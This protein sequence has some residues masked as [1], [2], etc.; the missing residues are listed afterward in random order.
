MEFLMTQVL[1][2]R[3]INEPPCTRY[4]GHKFILCKVYFNLKA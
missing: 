1:R 3:T 4:T 2:E